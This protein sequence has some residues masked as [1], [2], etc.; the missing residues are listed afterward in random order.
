MSRPRNAR[1]RNCPHTFA[2]LAAALA[3]ASC[4]SLLPPG[5]PLSKQQANVCHDLAR[6]SVCVGDRVWFTP[7]DDTP[8]LL[9]LFSSPESWENTRRHVNVFMLGPRHFEPAPKPE[10]NSLQDLIRVGA[11]VKLNSWGIKLA[12]EEGAVK[13]WDCTGNKTADVTLGHIQ[14]LRNSGA[15]LDLVAIDESL[16]SGIHACNLPLAA[17]AENTLNYIDKVHEGAARLKTKLPAIGDTEPYPGLTVDTL[18]SWVELL[19]QHK[20]SISFF[21][22]DIDLNYL[23]VH[24]EINALQDLEKLQKVL[25]V[26]GIPFGIIIWS[27]HD[28]VPDDEQYYKDAMELVALVKSLSEP[29]EQLIFESWVTRASLQCRLNASACHANSCS[30]Q[31]PTYC[32]LKSVPLNLPED[33]EHDFSHTR[34]IFDSLKAF[35]EK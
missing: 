26:H 22:L 34:L 14:N 8:D 13:E 23:H 15:N 11:F 6:N 16:V 1:S 30:K 31:D 5:Q 29:P 24:P 2:L 17:I 21:H 32:G 25:H 19:G 28:P 18:I 27:G 7:G 9:R 10:T 3:A 33:G 4:Q 35:S 12:S 20:D